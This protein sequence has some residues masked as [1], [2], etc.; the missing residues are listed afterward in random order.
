M[1]NLLACCALLLMLPAT[2]A[3]AQSD[4]D[5]SNYL[6]I[7]PR[8]W[9]MSRPRPTERRFTSP[10]GTAWVSLYAAPA[11]RESVRQH[12]ERLKHHFGRGNATYQ[13]DGGTWLV[14]SGYKGSRIFYRRTMLACGG[15]AWHT[16]EFEYPGAEKRAFDT[17]VTRASYALNAYSHEGCSG[18]T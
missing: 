6:S 2:A 12:I 8:D 9:T 5:A 7:I 10:D 1:R 18:P 4:R 16:L 11:G 3:Q 14:L 15:R 17:F 13:R